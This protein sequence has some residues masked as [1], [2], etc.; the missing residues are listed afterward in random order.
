MLYL[1]IFF[2]Q[3]DLGKASETRRLTR[4]GSP[5]ISTTILELGVS[6]FGDGMIKGGHS[7][8]LS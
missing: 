2:G 3:S 4:S 1:T 6:S 5:R 8:T 7:K